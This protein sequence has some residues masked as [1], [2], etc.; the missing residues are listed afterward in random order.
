MISFLKYFENGMPYAKFIDLTQALSLEAFYFTDSH[1]RQEALIETAN[2]IKM[3][4]EKV[5]LYQMTM[6][7]VRQQILFMVYTAVRRHFK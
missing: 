4:Y 6:I 3:K 2:Q 5:I 1:W 7:F